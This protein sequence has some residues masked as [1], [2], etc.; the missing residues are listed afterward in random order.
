MLLGYEIWQ[1][2]CKL[3]KFFVN[4]EVKWCPGCGNHGILKFIQKIFYELNLDNSK[5][6]F[7]F[8]EIIILHILGTMTFIV[9]S[10]IFF[11]FFKFG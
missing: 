1:Y 10:T 9:L 3:N 2:T 6:I 4:N 7:M 5:I 11:L 8:S